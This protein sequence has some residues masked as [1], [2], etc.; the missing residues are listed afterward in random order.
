MN[1]TID[2]IVAGHICLDLTPVFPETGSRTIQEILQPGRLV[3]IDGAEISLGGPVSNTG[4]AIHRFG[5]TM[6]ACAGI[7]DDP[8]GMLLL[9]QLD[10][11]APGSAILPAP[12][13]AT[14]FTIVLAPPGIDRI[15]IHCPGKNDTFSIDD[16]DIA[17]IGRARLFHLGYPPLLRRMYENEG[18]QLERI[19]ALAKEE[20]ATTSL[21][22]SLPDPNSPSG[23]APWPAILTRVLPYVDIF[24]PSLDEI[25]FM[26]DKKK[27]L[28]LKANHPETD[29]V[30]CISIADFRRLAD[31]VLAM[32]AGMC[33]IKA[34]RRGF[35]LRVGRADR[36]DRFGCEARADIASWENQELWAPSYRVPKIASATGSGDSSIAGFLTAFLRGFQPGRCTRLACAAGYYNMHALDSLSG[37]PDWKTLESFIDGNPPVEDP[38]LDDAI[39]EYDHTQ[40]VFRAKVHEGVKR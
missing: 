23:Q 27:Y 31:Q 32:G 12:D 8:L 3:N 40:R 11:Y 28:E 37:L 34:G 14:S 24:L 5:L 1:R 13:E 21:D 38:L 30:D 9:D 15:F 29:L 6:A 25:Y 20:G 7:G 39:F 26:L 19:F 22:M 33:V 18:Q 10:R 36:L 16:I 35:Y 17:T 4:L 2:V